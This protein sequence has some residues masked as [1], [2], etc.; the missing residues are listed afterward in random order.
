MVAPKGQLTELKLIGADAS[1]GQHS[2]LLTQYQANNNLKSS[3]VDLSNAAIYAVLGLGRD[4]KMAK[5]HNSTDHL[6][7]RSIKETRKFGLSY[8]ECKLMIQ[9]A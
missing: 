1:T 3:E 4:A 7:S 9:A 6:Q 5:T 2:F 8:N